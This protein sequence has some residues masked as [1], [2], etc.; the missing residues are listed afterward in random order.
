MNNKKD[1]GRIVAWENT[2]DVNRHDM[3]DALDDHRSGAGSDPDFKQNRDREGSA[4]TAHVDSS[5]HHYGIVTDRGTEPVETH[6]YR[7]N[8]FRE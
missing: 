4:H 7:R 3:S 8:D 2:Q 1:L 5:G 6:I